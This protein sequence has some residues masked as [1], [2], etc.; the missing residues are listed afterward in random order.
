MG[1]IDYVKRGWRQEE[2]LDIVKAEGSVRSRADLRWESCVNSLER[3]SF[4]EIGHSDT[5]EEQASL[6][7]LGAKFAL[8]VCKVRR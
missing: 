3:R 8:K 1:G 5:I 6:I 2:N 4:V 7:R